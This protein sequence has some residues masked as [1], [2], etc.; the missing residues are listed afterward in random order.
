MNREF[1]PKI[2]L[3][4]VKQIIILN[5]RE[6]GKNHSLSVSVLLVGL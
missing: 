2:R 1:D 6:R 3:I 4:P 5:P